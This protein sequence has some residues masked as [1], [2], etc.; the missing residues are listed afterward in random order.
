[1]VPKADDALDVRRYGDGACDDQ[2]HDS[3]LE[4]VQE[5]LVSFFVRDGDDLVVPADREP[6][7]FGI[8][9]RRTVPQ[10]EDGHRIE[11]GEIV[12]QLLIVHRLA[13]CGVLVGHLACYVDVVAC[14]RHEDIFKG[15]GR[16][17]H[18]LTVR[19]KIRHLA[20]L[21]AAPFNACGFLEPAFPD[22]MGIFGVVIA[23]NPS[24]SMLSTLIAVRMIS[25]F[26][27]TLSP[28]DRLR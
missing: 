23:W 13:H 27:G 24:L 12:H 3:L 22:A 7:C 4:V 19:V 21:P 16:V 11:I 15:A 26:D 25:V 14:I 6:V 8:E 5:P 2:R 17:G 20:F 18:H 28:N 9:L 10:S 1:M